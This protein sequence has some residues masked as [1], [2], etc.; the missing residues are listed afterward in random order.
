[1][2]CKKRKRKYYYVGFQLVEA[3]LH[4]HIPDRFYAYDLT[5]GQ[6]SRGVQ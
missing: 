4:D 3:I 5:Y 6:N 2:N 1:M